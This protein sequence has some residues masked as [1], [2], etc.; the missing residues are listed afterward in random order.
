MH[1]VSYKDLLKKDLGTIET[2]QKPV[3]IGDRSTYRTLLPE[4]TFI[5]WGQSTAL[6]VKGAWKKMTQPHISYDCE[7]IAY[8]RFCHLACH[9][10]L[11]F[12]IMMLLFFK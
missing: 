7:A 4:D 9:V 5:N 8:L 3:M 11:K 2:K 12:H 10:N 1:R 6:L